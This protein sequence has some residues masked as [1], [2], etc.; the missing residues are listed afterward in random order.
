MLVL[1]NYGL[2]LQVASLLTIHTISSVYLSVL[3]SV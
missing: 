1:V 2:M 3:N